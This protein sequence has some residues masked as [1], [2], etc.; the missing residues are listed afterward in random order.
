MNG[1]VF[2]PTA[3]PCKPD[4]SDSPSTP[5]FS[6]WDPSDERVTIGAHGP[7]LVDA[8]TAQ[9]GQDDLYVDVHVFPSATVC[10]SA[11]LLP[12]DSVSE[13]RVVLPP[14]TSEAAMALAQALVWAARTAATVTETSA[15]SHA[16]QVDGHV[17]DTTTETAHADEA[18]NGTEAQP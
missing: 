4:R 2:T 6:E 17:V 18:G 3:G 14:L 10:V 5:G 15:P 12:A 16:I 7:V 13:M 1:H 8:L 11:A 9:V